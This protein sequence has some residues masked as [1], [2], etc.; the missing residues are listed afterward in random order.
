MSARITENVLIAVLLTCS[1]HTLHKVVDIAQ[2][3]PKTFSISLS[4][5]A[6]RLYLN[7][8][9]YRDREFS[10]ELLLVIEDGTVLC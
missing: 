5:R 6:K 1:E 4:L 9:Q 10:A 8:L 3:D 2:D 7:T